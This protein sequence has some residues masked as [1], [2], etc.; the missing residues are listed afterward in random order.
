MNL[1]CRGARCAYASAARRR[2]FG[3]YQNTEPSRF[4]QEIPEELVDEVSTSASYAAVAGRRMP[5]YEMRVNPYGGPRR[6]PG[7]VREG[8]PGYRP[9]D[10]DQSSPNGLRPGLRVRHPHFGVGTVLS[11]EPGDADTKLTVRFNSVG[12][13]KLLAKFARLEPA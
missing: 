1:I 7:G 6:K 8:G 13:K 11:V 12:Q 3:E 2:V 4:L 9:E 5:A 10:E